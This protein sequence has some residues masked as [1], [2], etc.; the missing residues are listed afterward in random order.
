ME[1]NHYPSYTIIASTTTTTTATTTTVLPRDQE[2]LRL[3]AERG[4]TALVEAYHN[5]PLT[6]TPN[7]GSLDLREEVR[8]GKKIL[9]FLQFYFPVR[10]CY[11]FPTL[12]LCLITPVWQNICVVC[13]FARILLSFFWPV[14]TCSSSHLESGLHH[15][16]P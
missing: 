1:R 5:H 11:F 3:T 8:M 15:H 10:V 12:F 6:Y 4:D 13:L 7:G 9:P 14:H 16:Y 2:L